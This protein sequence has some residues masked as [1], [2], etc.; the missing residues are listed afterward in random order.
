LGV[1]IVDRVKLS[2]GAVGDLEGPGV[3]A[4]GHLEGR[5]GLVGGEGVDGRGDD[6]VSHGGVREV[7]GALH[8]ALVPLVIRRDRQHGCPQLGARCFG[9]RDGLRGQGT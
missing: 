5:R 1:E 8:A 7:P 4:G 6:S 2:P 9:H 3:V